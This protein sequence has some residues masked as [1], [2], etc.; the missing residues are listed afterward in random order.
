M[1][2][3]YLE[4]DKFNKNFYQELVQSV[5]VCLKIIDPSGAVLKQC[6]LTNYSTEKK[7]V[8]IH[9]TKTNISV[10]IPFQI[11]DKEYN[12]SVTYDLNKVP[13]F[14]KKIKAELSY[15]LEGLMDDL[16]DLILVTDCQGIVMAVNQSCEYIM[17]VTASEIIGKHVAELET[18]GIILPSVALRVL[19]SECRESIVQTTGSGRKLEVLGVPVYDENGKISRVVCRSR[20]LSSIEATEKRLDET[21]L[22]LERYQN[23]LLQMKGAAHRENF[24]FKSQKMQDIL[25]IVHKVAKVDSTV[26]LLGESGVGKEVVARLLHQLS[27]RNKGPF[28]KINCGAIPENLLE[29]ELFGYEAGAFT[30]AD[31][32]GKPGLIELAHNGTLLLDEVAELPLN[33]QVKLLRVIQEKEIA[34]LGGTKA[35]KINI[36]IISVTNR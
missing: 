12:L 29:S 26:M 6:R 33:L 21:R 27:S 28:I 14:T 20:D 5:P 15:I 22:V 10:N 30:G 34:R 3:H 11:E 16:Y 24:I 23:D 36:R 8:T 32:K 1:S 35:K 17:G 9:E 19:K 25:D 7:E 18:K 4:K 31:K 2:I 13:I